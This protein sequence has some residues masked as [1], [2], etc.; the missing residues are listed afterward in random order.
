[1]TSAFVLRAR[2]RIHALRGR[3]ATFVF[4]TTNVSL[5][6]PARSGIKQG[7]AVMLALIFIYVQEIHAN[8]LAVQMIGAFGSA[9]SP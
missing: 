6:A 8:M 9:V 5:S 7:L 1:M 3:V 2:R 4:R